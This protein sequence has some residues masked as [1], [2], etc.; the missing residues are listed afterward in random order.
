[1]IRPTTSGDTSALIALAETSGLFDRNQIDELSQMVAQH[2]DGNG[3]SRDF[4]ITDDDNGLVGVAY[5]APERM[6]E[7]TWNLYLI[8]VHPDRQRAR[9]R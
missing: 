3:N 8:A 2:F 4:W 5:V 1:M 9:T 7:G 6:T